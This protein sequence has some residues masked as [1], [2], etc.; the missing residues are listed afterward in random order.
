[1]FAISPTDKDWFKFLRKE[2]LN[3]EINFW[4]PTPWN[5]SRLS[6]GDRLYFILK[7]PIRKIGGYGEF[8]EYKNM[9]VGE[10]WNKFGLRNGCDSKE[11]LIDRLSKYKTLHS[12]D[13]RNVVDSEIGCIVLTNSL[14]YDDDNFLD[15]RNYSIDFSINIVKIKYFWGEDPLTVDTSL[16]SNEFKLIPSSVQKE[17]KTRLVT[18]RKGQGGFKGI[19]SEAYSN[20]CCITNETIP[21]LLEAAHIQPYINEKSNHVK[22]GLLLRI[23][24][25][26]LYDNGLIYIDKL[27]KVHVSPLVKGEYY[28]NLNGA[29]IRLPK[30]KSKYPSI[31]ALE[32]RKTEFRNE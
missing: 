9:S 25:H 4:T 22:N 18:E 16:V 11:E 17:K 23:D 19:I 28:Q 12:S 2:G 10:A 6:S 15:L 24:L 20:K 32:V 29:T 27:F 21:E 31:A 26:K 8:V 30:D 7:S 1:M 3:S 5:I 14:F 13:E